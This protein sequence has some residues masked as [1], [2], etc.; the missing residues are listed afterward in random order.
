MTLGSERAKWVG[1]DL[2]LQV[3]GGRRPPS[4]GRVLGCCG[5][6]SVEMVGDYHGS[7][8]MGVSHRICCGPGLS[9]GGQEEHIKLAVQGR[10]AEKA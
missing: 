3:E 7:P 10:W 1:A 2:A 6:D 4:L 5:M 9:P 8:G